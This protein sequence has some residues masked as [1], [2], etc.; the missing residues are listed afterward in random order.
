MRLLSRRRI[1]KRRRVRDRSGS[2]SA[3]GHP[4]LPSALSRRLESRPR[5]SAGRAEYGLPGHPAGGWVRGGLSAGGWVKGGLSSQ[6]RYRP[7]R[8]IPRVDID[9]DGPLNPRLVPGSVSLVSSCGSSSTIRPRPHT[10]TRVRCVPGNSRSLRRIPQG[11]VSP[12]TR[13]TLKSDLRGAPATF[14]SHDPFRMTNI[15]SLR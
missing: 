9:E 15:I 11:A 6:A 7:P 4:A 13:W 5:A 12:R 1:R 2:R 14:K 8:H 3:A 10:L